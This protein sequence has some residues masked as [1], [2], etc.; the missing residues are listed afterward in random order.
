MASSQ[1]PPVS[2]G[3]RVLMLVILAAMF[4]LSL[5]ANAQRWRRDKVEVVTVTPAAPSVSPSAS[6]R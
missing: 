2:K 6:P 1:S 5:Y 3:L 4:L